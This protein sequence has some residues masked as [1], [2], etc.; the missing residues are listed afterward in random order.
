[1]S[2]Q[3][4]YA[5]MR[6]RR[7]TPTA[8]RRERAALHRS[9]RARAHLERVRGGKTPRRAPGL[10]LAAPIAIAASLI[11]GALFGSPLVA[12]AR[13]WIAGAPIR[14]ES[15]SV[16]G[17]G[18]LS[19]TEI[20]RATALPKGVLIAEIEP[21][22][23]EASLLTHPWISDAAVVRLPASRLL[24]RITERVARAVVVIAVGESRD[25]RAWRVVSSAGLPF[26]SAS[27]SDIES[28]P[29]LVTQSGLS[30]HELAANEPSETFAEAIELTARFS[31]FD[32]P[33][34]SEVVIDDGVGSEGWVVRLPS[35]APRVV[36]G[37]ENL[38]DRLAALAE[39]VDADRK[40][41]AEAEAIDLRFAEQAVLRSTPSSEGTAQAA[42]T[43]GSVALPKPRPTG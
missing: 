13:S 18:R 38:D 43:R 3:R 30:N 34:P 16:S 20:G 21:D 41:L 27:D 23:V 4:P 40:E 10:S 14:L 5:G 42:T 1:M 32:L 15:I 28:L 35:L 36:L 12:A 39:L 9:E 33:I 7:N 37:H 25:E 17:A 2:E 24:I 29:R 8:S 22:E 11:V 19:L 26:A 31:A 6:G